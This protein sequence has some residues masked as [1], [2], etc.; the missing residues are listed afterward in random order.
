MARGEFAG[1]KL[2]RDRQSKRWLNKWW[3]RKALHIKERFDPLEGAPQAKGIVLKKEGK[4]QK[5]PHSGIIKC[6]R[7]QL[8]KNGKKV[9]AHVP[10]DK[11]I[12]KIDEHDEVT[13]EGLGGSQR[14]QMGSIPGVRYKVMAVNGVSL[15]ELRKGKKEKPK[16]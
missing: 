9:S 8:I 3:K 16:R 14:G 4:E 2:K 5:Q 15:S 10:R 7:V 1:R 6:V 11:A 13:I 12:D